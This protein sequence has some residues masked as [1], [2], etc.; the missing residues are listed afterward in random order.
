MCALLRSSCAKVLC[1]VV[2][3]LQTMKDIQNTFYIFDDISKRVDCFAFNPQMTVI[4][5]I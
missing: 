3:K 2:N 5:I 4:K 1:L